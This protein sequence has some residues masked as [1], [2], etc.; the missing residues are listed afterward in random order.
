MATVRLGGPRLV[1]PSKGARCSNAPPT[2]HPA[3]YVLLHWHHEHCRQLAE[4]AAVRVAKTYGRVGVEENG[5]NR[6]K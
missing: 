5:R 3:F 6:R 4:V 2:T 1:G